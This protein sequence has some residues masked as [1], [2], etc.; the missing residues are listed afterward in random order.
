MRKEEGGGREG[1][2]EGGKQKDQ[3]SSELK[4]VPPLN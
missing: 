3:F 1:G 4:D 2:R